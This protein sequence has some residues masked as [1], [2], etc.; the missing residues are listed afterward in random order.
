MLCEEE[1][2]KITQATAKKLLTKKFGVIQIYETRRYLW[3]NSDYNFEHKLREVLNKN[4]NLELSLMVS[5][6]FKERET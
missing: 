2:Q 6:L 3:E 4:G 5:P 1:P